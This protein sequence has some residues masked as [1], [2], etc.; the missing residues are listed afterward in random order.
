M[1]RNLYLVAVCLAGALLLPLGILA[2]MVDIEMGNTVSANSNATFTA[3]G[4]N[5][6]VNS[7]GVDI[8]TD[9]TGNVSLAVSASLS[10]LA[11]RTVATTND[12]IAD[13]W[14]DPSDTASRRYAIT[15]KDTF[16]LTVSNSCVTA[17]EYRAVVRVESAK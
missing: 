16:T 7:V 14:I 1:R 11:S 9:A 6:W 13:V 8:G 4:V 3:K 17:K 12:C 10:S 15:D 5:G 2:G